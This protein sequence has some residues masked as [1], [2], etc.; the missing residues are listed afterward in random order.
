MWSPLQSPPTPTSKV[1]QDMGSSCGISVR[2]SSFSVRFSSSN[3]TVKMAP[4]GVQ[5]PI[6]K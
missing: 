6:I 5:V 1:I 3:C 2:F 4:G